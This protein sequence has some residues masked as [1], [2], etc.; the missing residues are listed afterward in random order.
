MLREELLLERNMLHDVKKKITEI[1]SKQK[2]ALIVGFVGILMT[3]AGFIVGIPLANPTILAVFAYIGLFV[4]I[5]SGCFWIYFSDRKSKTIKE[6]KTY[7][8]MKA[9]KTRSGKTEDWE[10]IQ[11]LLSE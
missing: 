7:L 3:A 8:A 6:F 4:F 10:V 1:R 2:I 9:L 5:L 11:E